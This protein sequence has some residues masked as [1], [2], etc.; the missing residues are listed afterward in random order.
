MKNSL[1]LLKTVVVVFFIAS[2]VSVNIVDIEFQSSE[3]KSFIAFHTVIVAS[4]IASQTAITPFLNHS[5]LFHKRTKT[6]ITA[7]ITIGTIPIA[8]TTAVIAGIIVP[9][10]KPATFAKAPTTSGPCVIIVPIDH[11]SLPTI[12]RI[13]P[14]AAIK[15]PMVAMIPL[16][17]SGSA[18]IPFTSLVKKSTKPLTAG[19]NNSPKDM[20]NSSKADF[21]ILSCPPKLSCIVFAIFSADPSALYIASLKLL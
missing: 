6:A 5:H 14:I 10:T 19:I 15:T 18:F 4:F 2:H 17:G 13:G 11:T 9:V 7:P 16:T 20:A 8:D 1:I 12:T 21:N 3:K